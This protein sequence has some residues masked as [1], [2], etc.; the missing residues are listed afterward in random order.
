M[1][2]RLILTVIMFMIVDTVLMGVGAPLILTLPM[3]GSH[4]MT[5][6]VPMIEGAAVISLTASFFI[7]PMLRARNET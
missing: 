2:N 3:F 1:V 7:A 5:Y 6:F 4:Q